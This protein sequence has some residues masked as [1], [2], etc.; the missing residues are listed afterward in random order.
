MLIMHEKTQQILRKY[1]FYEKYLRKYLFYEKY[2][3]MIF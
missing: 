1:L 3:L 2:K